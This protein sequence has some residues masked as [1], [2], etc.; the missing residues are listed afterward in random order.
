MAIS[1]VAFDLFAR[2]LKDVLPRL[3]ES[4]CAGRP[5]R[6]LSLGYIDF[7]VSKDHVARL[8][9]Q[10]VADQVEVRED[11]SAIAA[12]HGARAS[13]IDADTFY[14]ALGI[15]ARYLDIAAIRGGE[16]IQDLNQPLAPELR[17]Q[18]DLLID[19]G[20]LE[21]CFNV[22]QAMANVALALRV[23]GIVHHGNPLL[24]LNHGFFNFSPAFYHD[25]YRANGFKLLD[26]YVV[27]PQPGD[28]LRLWPAHGAKRI[29][30][31]DG[32]ERVIQV[33]AQK[34]E[35]RPIAWPT[36]TKYEDNPGLAG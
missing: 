4:G 13:V 3:A 8:F 2:V 16:I 11:S 9:G 31:P 34:V 7:I 15:E 25:F 33:L 12:W 36:Q 6:L 35:E 10:A 1:G 30:L 29:R 21:H 26:M 28:K 27:E 24:M 19:S 20:T 23:G 32:A 17:G 5:V 14:R 22:G 18:F